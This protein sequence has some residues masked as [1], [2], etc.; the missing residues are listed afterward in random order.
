VL[1]RSITPT[2]LIALIITSVAAAALWSLQRQVSVR[3]DGQRDLR[4][5]SDA[6]GQTLRAISTVQHGYVAPGQL[7]APLFDEMAAL[8]ARL[9]DQ[10]EALTPLLNPATAAAH[11]EALRNSLDMLSETDG[12]ARNNLRRGQELMAADVIYSDGRNIVESI[13]RSL[14]ELEEAEQASVAESTR[15]AIALMW[16]LFGVLTIVWASAC[17]GATRF[18]DVTVVSE[19]EPPVPTASQEVVPPVDYPALAGLCTDLSRVS[20]SSRLQP[21]FEQCARVMRAS[22]VMLWMSAGD[23]L[24]PALAHGYPRGVLSQLGP[25]A[26]NEGNATAEAWRDGRQ[27]VQQAA[28]GR[29]AA[30][31]TP[32]FGPDACVGVLAVELQNN[33]AADTQVATAASVIAA[34]LATIIAAWPAAS[35]PDSGRTSRARTA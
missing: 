22:G 25:M 14:R 5:R 4:A 6:A 28:G 3:I 18:R 20:E 23:R 24:F 27:V 31:V 32:L 8:L 10:V 17:L 7:D 12:R 16:G 19:R 29:G 26:R 13:A 30:V 2:I 11:T 35:T 34:Q 15:R 33:V 9:E 1:R 21:L